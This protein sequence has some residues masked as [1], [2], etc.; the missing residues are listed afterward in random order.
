MTEVEVCS[1]EALPSL[2][3]ETL[4]VVATEPEVP[5]A[6]SQ[7]PAI[8]KVLEPLTELALAEVLL[9]PPG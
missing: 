5:V 6:V 4:E 7:G 9:G 2:A 8:A 3:W 1:V